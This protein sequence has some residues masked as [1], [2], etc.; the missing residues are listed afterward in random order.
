MCHLTVP[1]SEC[2]RWTSTA[3]G[4]VTLTHAQR[5]TVRCELLRGL[6]DPDDEGMTFDDA[7]K[8][9]GGQ[10]GAVTT[11]RGIRRR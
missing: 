4:G 6:S 5:E 11:R 1:V 2:R 10:E 8:G 7:R 3:R 9:E